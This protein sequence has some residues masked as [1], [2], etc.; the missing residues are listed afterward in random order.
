MV[1]EESDP[2]EL[3]GA[4]IA[5]C[6]WLGCIVGF[7]VRLWFRCP[8]GGKCRLDRGIEEVDDLENRISCSA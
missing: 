1:L 3:V 7:G 8:L 5:A 4:V 2:L 6:G